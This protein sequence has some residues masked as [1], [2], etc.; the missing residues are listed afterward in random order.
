MLVS[1][2][3]THSQCQVDNVAQHTDLLT[4]ILLPKQLYRQILFHSTSHMVLI[5][6]AV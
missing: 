5:K 1:I 4:S 3:N 2:L 6:N